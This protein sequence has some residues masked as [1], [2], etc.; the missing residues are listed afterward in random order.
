MNF[1]SGGGKR[2]LLHSK[3]QTLQN[4]VVL[5]NDRK[6]AATKVYVHTI[7]KRRYNSSMRQFPLQKITTFYDVKTLFLVIK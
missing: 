3:E 2:V 4:A 6:I 7:R 1:V 5:Q